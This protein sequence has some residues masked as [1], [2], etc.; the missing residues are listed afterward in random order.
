V[1]EAAASEAAREFEAH[2][3]HLMGL[4]YRMLGSLAEAEDAVQEAY[5]RWHGADR[6]AVES[7]RAFLSTILTRLCLDQL[8][9]ARARRESYVGPWLPEPVLDAAA[10]DPESASDYA[11]DLSVALM[12][13]LERLSPLER[14][15]FL[16]HD[17]F[18]M[19]FADVARALGRGEAACRQ[20]ASR[21]RAHV[22]AARP[23]F[24]PSP[25]EGARLAAAFRQAAESGDASAM[26]RLLAADAVLYSDG[27]GKRR[28]ALNP[29]RGADKIARFFAG[30]AQKGHAA[31]WR[32][33]EAR[34]NGLPGFVLADEAGSVQT[35]AFAV[36][37]G[38]ITA[39]YLVANPDKLRR[40]AF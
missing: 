9:S 4:A 39:I 14:A 5:L 40:V 33:R 1:S 22:Q 31:H 35:S 32:A 36:E 19:E 28:A 21:A 16:L 8:K 24:K 29:I 7:P 18:D 38:R 30:I 34:I 6:G 15:A 26:A 20:L 11:H 27:G 13:T 37:D 25:D 3:R 23:R 17:V 12:L 2:R 10:L